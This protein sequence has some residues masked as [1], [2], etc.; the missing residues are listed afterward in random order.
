MVLDCEHVTSYLLLVQYSEVYVDVTYRLLIT[1]MNNL[2]N[3]LLLQLQWSGEET[4]FVVYNTMSR[5]YNNCTVNM[6]HTC[7]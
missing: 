3:I 7:T 4:Q 2:S 1:D 5:I 6:L